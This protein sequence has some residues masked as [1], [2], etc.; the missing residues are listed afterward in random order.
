MT[1][2]SSRQDPAPL[3]MAMRDGYGADLVVDAAGFSPTLKLALDVVRPC[4]QIN[5]IGWGPARSASR[6]ISSFPRQW[7]CR[8]LSATTGMY[9]KNVWF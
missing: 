9:G 3:I 8:E 1:V 4:G 6:W 5:K 7:R 2:N